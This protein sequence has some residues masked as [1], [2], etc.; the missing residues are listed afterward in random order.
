MPT[1]GYLLLIAIG[2]AILLPFAVSLVRFNLKRHVIIR[3]V[4]AATAAQLEAVYGIIEAAAAKDPGACLLVRSNEAAPSNQNVVALPASLP[5]CPWAGKRLEIRGDLKDKP[6]I[7]VV[8]A[9][10][11]A[12]SALGGQLFRPLR[13]PA[14]RG[15]SRRSARNVYAPSAL[16]RMLPDLQPTLAAICPQHPTDTLTYLLGPG[17]ESYEYEPL[18]QCRIASGITW[19][20]GPEEP[21][22]IACSTPPAFIMQIP[23]EMLSPRLGEANFY[24]FG[25]RTH[26][27]HLMCLT[28]YF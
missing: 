17:T 9:T 5:E 6:I 22:C 27:T 28:Q 14:R 8:D 11:E 13:L 24:V 2:A 1:F 18:A 3:S 15:K 12:R 4:R 16:L 20:Q 7:A 23:G 21:Q 19:I 26:T 10:S 25:C